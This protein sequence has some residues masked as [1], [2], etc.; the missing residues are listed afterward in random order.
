VGYS[1]P[2]TTTQ[3]TTMIIA[4]IPPFDIVIDPEDDPAAPASLSPA[5]EPADDPAS[6][7]EGLPGWTGADVASEEK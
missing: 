1:L 7:A 3:T 6:P 5:L 4:M 2:N